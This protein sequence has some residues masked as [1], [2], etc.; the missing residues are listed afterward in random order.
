MNRWAELH[1]EYVIRASTPVDEL[2]QVAIEGLQGYFRS[3][4]SPEERLKQAQKVIGE[5]GLDQTKRLTPLAIMPLIRQKS[6]PTGT[7]NNAE[8]VPHDK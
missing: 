8:G 3:H 2:S 4:P 6:V 1:R 7:V 5:D